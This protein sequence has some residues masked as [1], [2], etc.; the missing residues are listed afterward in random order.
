MATDLAAFAA[1]VQ[2]HVNLGGTVTPDALRSCAITG[3]VSIVTRDSLA[4][5]I[6]ATLDR[7]WAGKVVPKAPSDLAHVIADAIA[8]RP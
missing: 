8:G 4:D 2:R 6:L 3:K 1:A 7:E 5:T